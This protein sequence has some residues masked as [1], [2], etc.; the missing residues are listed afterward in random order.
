MDGSRR[1]RTADTPARS[2]CPISFALE[3]FGDIWSLLIVRDIVYFG[4]M[5]FSEFLA[6]DE[7]IARNILS[8]RLS[9]LVRR[10]ILTKRLDQAD[11]RREIYALTEAGLDLI[12]MVLEL[13]VW[14]AEHAE[15]T[16]APQAWIQAV[17][18]RRDEIIP[19]IRDGVRAGRS[20]FAGPDRVAERFIG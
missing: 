20:V 19:A 7:G 15:E 8:D 11:R 3:A 16:D 6:S 9:R 2:A 18:T 17:R 14:G 12:P 10:G 1:T 4:K 5:T 13:A